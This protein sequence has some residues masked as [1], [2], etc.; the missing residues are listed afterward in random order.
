MLSKRYSHLIRLFAIISLSYFLAG[1]GDG[2]GPTPVPGEPCQGESLVSFDADSYPENAE[3]AIINLA[4]SCVGLQTVNLLVDTG[5]RQL[6]QCCCV[7]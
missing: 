3:S 1:C 7:N 6:Y 5:I 2:D 4:D